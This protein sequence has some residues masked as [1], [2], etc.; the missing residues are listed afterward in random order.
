MQSTFTLS[1]IT[2]DCQDV[3]ATAGFWSE[4]LAAPL[5][6][7]LPGWRRLGPL[8]PGGPVLTFQPV[9]EAKQGKVRLHLDLQVD[10]LPAAIA[11]VQRLGG[12]SLD[13]VHEYEEGTVA[14]LAD[15]EGNEF[16]LVWR[17]DGSSP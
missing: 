12:R 13:E 9:P 1:G 17:R 14:V 2:L 7:S 8:T 15:V 16:C 6:E 3:E 11:R 4:L 5:Q 10:D